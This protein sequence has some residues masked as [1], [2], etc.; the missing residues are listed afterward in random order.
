M[1]PA[2]AQTY[3]RAPKRRPMSI[4]L[5]QVVGGGKSLEQVASRMERSSLARTAG[6]PG[7]ETVDLKTDAGSHRTDDGNL[8]AAVTEEYLDEYTVPGGEHRPVVKAR[9]IDIVFAPD[10]G[11]LLVFAGR[12]GAGPIAPKVSGIVYSAKD[13]PVLSCG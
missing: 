12:Q 5:F 2:R 10:A 4:T 1:R 6:R 8:R 11:H 13:S 7:G 9:T 3:N